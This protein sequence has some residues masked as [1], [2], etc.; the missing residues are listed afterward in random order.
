MRQNEKLRSLELGRFLAALLI[1]CSHVINYIR[2]D[3]LV[4][5]HGFLG[6]FA[7]FTRPVGWHWR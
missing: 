5:G 2:I 7:G 6:G 4:A 3:P 1:M